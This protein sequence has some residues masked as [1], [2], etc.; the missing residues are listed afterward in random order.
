MCCDKAK[1]LEIQ[2][3]YL[4]V[5]GISTYGNISHPVAAWVV[6][7]TAS[8]TAALMVARHS[9]Q[10]IATDFFSIVTAHNSSELS[11]HIKVPRFSA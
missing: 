11:N 1:L 5:C 8:S 7:A 10:C 6:M 9:S 2:L 4:Y 3:N